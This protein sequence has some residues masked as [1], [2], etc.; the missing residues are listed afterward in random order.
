MPRPVLIV[1]A[2]PD[3][4]VLGCGGTIARHIDE[5]DIVDIV[6]MA[7]GVSSRDLAND[8]ELACRNAAAESVGKLLGCRNIYSL[9]L[10][11]NRLD[12][13]ALI[14]VIKPLES[15]IKEIKPEVIYT[16][17]CGDL[18][19]DHRITHQAVMTACRPQPGFCVRSIYAFEIMSS[20]EWQTAGLMPFLPN[21][22][23]DI[24]P[25][26]AL[27]KR[28]LDLYAAEMREP[29]HSRSLAGLEHLAS[30]RGHCVG[31]MAAEAFVLVRSVR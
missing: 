19:I 29:P 16:H 17:H 20:T 18:N 21:V 31:L 25:F 12:A 22:F 7:D 23:V 13:Y 30:H 11:D 5:G 27:K 15:L 6:F 8:N 10:K 26:M 2:H 1:A 9:G 24:T 28:A 4:E 14:D 3:D